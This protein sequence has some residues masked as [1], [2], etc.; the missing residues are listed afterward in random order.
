[1]KVLIPLAVLISP[2]ITS[3]AQPE[4]GGSPAPETSLNGQAAAYAGY[5]DPTICCSNNEAESPGTAA[6][7]PERKDYPYQQ[8]IEQQAKAYVRNGNVQI[9]DPSE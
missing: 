6:R 4:A 7:P 9:R 1:M 3:H 5:A 2:V 8:M